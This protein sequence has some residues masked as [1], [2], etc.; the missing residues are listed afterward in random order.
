[1]TLSLRE[2][3]REL[4]RLLSG[5]LRSSVPLR[6]QKQNICSLHSSHIDQPSA[7]MPG[8]YRAAVAG[9]LG[10]LQSDV[11]YG[12]GRQPVLDTAGPRAR[13]RRTRHQQ[14]LVPRVGPYPRDQ[15]D[16]AGTS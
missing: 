4:F 1:M 8:V 3:S 2:R 14:R 6:Q 15:Y 16:G 11:Q 10:A 13:G 5:G 12:P 7:D 9:L